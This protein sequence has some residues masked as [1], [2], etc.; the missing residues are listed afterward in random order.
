[1]S[2]VPTTASTP[3]L[4]GSSAATIPPNTTTSATNVNGAVSSSERLRSCSACW[5]IWRAISALPVTAVVMQAGRGR[6]PLGEPFGDL[7]LVVETTLHRP[8]HQGLPA[9]VALQRGQ[10]PGPVRRGRRRCPARPPALRDRQ[11]GSPNR[12]VVDA[13]VTRGDEHD[14]VRLAGI[15]EPMLDLGRGARRLGPRI[16]HATDGQLLLD[17]AADDRGEGQE[18]QGEHDHHPAAMHH[19]QREPTHPLPPE[20]AAP[21]AGALPTRRRYATPPWARCRRG[22]RDQRSGSRGGGPWRGRSGSWR[23]C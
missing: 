16:F 8:E 22:R 6:V 20:R 18:Q 10:V 19:E 15:G 1:M 4:S 12:R 17:V 3:T 13:A 23:S 5:L 2:R 11:A 21:P 14:E 9:V 7:D